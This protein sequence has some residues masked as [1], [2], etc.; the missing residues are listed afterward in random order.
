MAAGD[1]V[2]RRNASNTDTIPDAGSDLLLLW[3]TAVDSEGSGITYSAGTF[4]LGE[5]GNFLVI[6]SDQEGTTSTTNNERINTKMTITLAGSE[7]DEG[8]STGYIRKSGGSQECVQ[9]MMCIIN[10][11]TTTGNG[12]ELQI[13]KERIDDTTG[14]GEEPDRIASRSGITIIKLDDSWNYGRY[15]SSAAFA[16]SGTDNAAVT[17]NIQTT[18]EEDSPFTRSTNTVDIATT[19]YVLALYSLKSEDASPSGRA[20]YQGRLTLNSTPIPGSYSQCYIRVTDN[21]DW[22]GMCGFALI[23]PTSGDD[24]ELEVVSRE[25]GGE[26]FTATL[27][28]VELPSSA[29]VALLEETTGSF[30]ET[31]ATNFNWTNTP[32]IIDTDSFTYDATNDD[33]DVDEADDYLVFAGFADDTAGGTGAQRAVPSFLF[34]VN[35]TDD[36]AGGNSCYN[37]SSGTAEHSAIAA[38]NLLTGLSANDTIQ[39]RISA[40]GTLNTD[41]TADSAAF[42]LIRL[43]TLFTAAAGITSIDPTSFRMDDSDV[44]INGANFEATQNSGSVYLSDATTLA[45]SAN[46]VDISSAVNTW[47]DV[48][49]NLDLTQL[50]AGELSDLQTLGP[51]TRYIILVNDSS[52]EYASS[53]ITLQRP[54]AFTLSASSNIAASG[55]ATTAQLTAPSGKTTGDFVAGRI[56]DDE[57]PSDA[58]DAAA[59]EYTEYEWSIE[60]TTDAIDGAVYDFRIVL[61]DGTV[62][63][64]Y[65]VTPQWTITSVTNQDVSITFDLNNNLTQTCINAALAQISSNSNL[66]ENIN[67]I[68]NVFANLLVSNIMNSDYA[69]KLNSFADIIISKNMSLSFTSKLNITATFLEGSSIQINNTAVASKLA[70]LISNILLASPIS[71][72]KSTEASI[73]NNIN[74]QI[75]IGAILNTKSFVEYSLA[76]QVNLA[77]LLDNAVFITEDISNNANFIKQLDITSSLLNNFDLTD[78]YLSIAQ[79]SSNILY[80]L[81]ENISL[82]D[83]AF[84]YAAVSFDADQTEDFVKTRSTTVEVDI[85]SLLNEQSQTVISA[86]GE[87]LQNINVIDSIVRIS[88]QLAFLTSNKHVVYNT[89]TLGENQ[90]FLNVSTNLDLDNSG[91]ADSFADTSLDINLDDIVETDGSIAAFLAL[92]HIMEEDASA[93]ILIGA[94]CSFLLQLSIIDDV[95]ASFDSSVTYGY[96]LEKIVSAVAASIGV[97]ENETTLG[98]TFTKSLVVESGVIIDLVISDDYNGTIVSAN[99][100]TPDGRCVQVS[101]SNRAAMLSANRIIDTTTS[102]KIETSGSRCVNFKRGC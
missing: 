23:E 19:N 67:N 22:G 66:Q 88:E 45:G 69:A 25:L 64:T 82:L 102:E 52:D 96:T 56:Q 43:S 75:N 2:K 63:D 50:S 74:N 86:N 90:V 54:V 85:N 48:L 18:D 76:L 34:R 78:E 9:S 83:K 84:K 15:S 73:T 39:T 94:N 59:D 41:I 87:L 7:I 26:D 27:Q 65:T 60:A 37:R 61:S 31:T 55:A 95:I 36:E 8:Y 62:L 1:F 92:S 24:L 70:A 5:T 51:G 10:V 71:G 46:E 93:N 72:V 47:S 42:A 13:R 17:A 58:V 33:I 49:V 32:T 101:T 12:D 6:C 68:S 28:L 53:A 30:N 79:L 77:G 29:E 99:V 97:F 44:D 89:V 14:T 100:I 11:A 35:T 40:L 20:E 81:E 38:G 3:D 57:N 91:L 21:C 98:S 4:T 80:N 16:S